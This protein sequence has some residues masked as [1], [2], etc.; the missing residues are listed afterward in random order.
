MYFDFRQL[1]R[2]CRFRDG[3]TPETVFPGRQ[4]II[5]G[6]HPCHLIREHIREQAHGGERLGQRVA[7][8]ADL[9]EQ[10]AGACV[11]VEALCAQVDRP[12]E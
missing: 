9:D 1:R 8:R 3:I 2:N 5:R 7:G 12:H 11:L 4:Q 6:L 10:R